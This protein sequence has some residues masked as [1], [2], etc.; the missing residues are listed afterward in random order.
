MTTKTAAHADSARDEGTPSSARDP[1]P[2]SSAAER[3]EKWHREHDRERAVAEQRRE[4]ELAESR[5]Q[6]RQRGETLRADVQA[7]IEAHGEKVGELRKAESRVQALRAERDHVPADLH[8]RIDEWVEAAERRVRS[9]FASTTNA[10]PNVMPRPKVDW[11][12][13]WIMA[14]DPKVR[15]MWHAAADGAMADSP[16]YSDRASKDIEKDLDGAKKEVEQARESE[17]DAMEALG[18]AR[19]SLHDWG[20]GR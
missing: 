1:G 5:E 20:A 6:D 14:T 12:G 7:A 13:D 15:E 18:A 16:T 2:A 3:A 8:R 11:V 17:R 4:V 9:T 19:K 10:L